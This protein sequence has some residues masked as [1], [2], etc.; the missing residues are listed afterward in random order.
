MA[1]SGKISNSRRAHQ[2]LW[3]PALPSEGSLSMNRYWGELDRCRREQPG[4]GLSIRSVLKELPVETQR[5]N[6]LLRFWQ[7]YVLYP[8]RVRFQAP[9]ARVVH[10]LDHSNA[11]LLRHVPGNVLKIATVHDLAPLRVP[12]DLTQAQQERFRRSMSYLR[13]ADLLLAV[14]KHTAADIVELLGCEEGRIRVLPMGADLVQAGAPQPEPLPDW[15]N[16]FAGR[17][18][19]IS[20]GSTT[21]RKNLAALPAFL[22]QLKRDGW[23]VALVRV[24]DEL[25]GPLAAELRAVL[26]AE[27][28]VEMGKVSTEQLAGAYQRAAFLIFPSRFEGF[29][30]PVL[31]AMAAGCPVVCSSATSLP[32]VGGPAALYFPPDDIAMAVSQA[33]LLLSREEYRQSQIA[34]GQEWSQNFSWQKHFTR[35]TDYYREL[36]G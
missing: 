15:E 19:V 35:L 16:R 28:L 3:L 23:P 5:K 4:S 18:V 29:G 27:G 9:Y 13:K 2:V 21:E 7:K 12:G 25:P 6:R 32:E 20:V 34:A 24:G 26:G 31:E 11:S 30:L 10:L 36:L 22:A 33:A 8:W 14:S 17:R 1:E